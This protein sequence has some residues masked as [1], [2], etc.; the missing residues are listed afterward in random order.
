MLKVS[1]LSYYRFW[2][3]MIEI[4]MIVWFVGNLDL[5]NDLDCFFLLLLCMCEINLWS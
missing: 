3:V 4:V 1:K 5:N 2:K